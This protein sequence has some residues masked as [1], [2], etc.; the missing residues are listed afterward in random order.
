M[1]VLVANRSEIAC[2]IFATLRDMGWPSVAVYSPTDKDSPHV[3]SADEAY[4]LEETYDYLSIPKILNI[5]RLSGA[6]AIHPGYGFL[7]ERADFAEACQ[8]AGLR[9]V[10]PDPQ[11]TRALGDKAAA[12]GL[13][14]KVG[15][16]VVPGAQSTATPEQAL[17]IAQS[18]GFPILIKAAGGGGGKGMRQVHTPAELP[19]AFSAAQR[20]A[21]KAFGDGRLLIEKYVYPARHIEIQIFGDG[22]TIATLGERECSLQRRYQKIIEE[23]PSTAVDNT[24]RQQL[25]DAASTLAQ[26]A[27]YKNAGTV[28]FIVDP[29]G[30]FYFLEV[31]T[32]LQVEHPITEWRHG[33]DLVRWQL[34]F[35]ET[36]KI[37]NTPPPQPHGHTIEVRL[38]AEDPYNQFLPATG[39]VDV[40]EFPQRPY[41]RIDTGIV[42]GQVISPFYDSLLAKV[43]TW[44]EN[45]EQ[46]RHRMLDV[47][48]KTTVLGLHTNQS[49]L[50]QLLAH[51]MFVDGRTFTTSVEKETWSRP[52]VEPELLKWVD[53][54][55][56]TKSATNASTQTR[57]TWRNM[58]HFRL[59]GRP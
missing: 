20:E 47:L 44:G 45:R 17:A 51:P 57:N 48:R 49:F 16:P 8:K 21:Q 3:W 55:G 53:E 24:L 1:K 29:E 50:L 4:A 42:E 58:G 22:H 2:R 12:R 54:T 59:G 31:N 10:G 6:E 18:L 32:R 28:E 19:D 52:S 43:I 23:S 40:L 9:F 34:E 14:Q 39:T 11:S 37:P 7:A 27:R 30:H 5:A 36:G 15:V 33:I 56:Q 13:A 38:C 41:A 26:Q 35:L 46:A 25:C